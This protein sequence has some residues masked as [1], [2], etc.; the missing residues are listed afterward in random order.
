MFPY[1]KKNVRISLGLTKECTPH[2]NIGAVILFSLQ[3]FI[4]PFLD[5][6]TLLPPSF[7]GRASR[8]LNPMQEKAGGRQ[9]K[10]NYCPPNISLSCLLFL[11]G[12]ST[13]TTRTTARTTI[14]PPP[15]RPMK[16]P[17]DERD[18]QMSWRGPTLTSCTQRAR[19][20]GN[21]LIKSFLSISVT[22]LMILSCFDYQLCLVGVGKVGMIKSCSKIA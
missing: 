19:P 7:V 16:R 8:A 4:A 18:R 17:E 13:G 22:L 12:V 2:I 20:P 11:L 15:S 6:M 9:I 5:L 14:A 10:Q 3:H 21:S 1:K